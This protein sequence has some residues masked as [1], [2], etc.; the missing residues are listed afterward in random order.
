MGRIMPKFCKYSN[1]C[2][3]KLPSLTVF[4]E[5]MTDLTLVYWVKTFLDNIDNVVK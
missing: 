5:K 4:M 1:W 3:I 2:K